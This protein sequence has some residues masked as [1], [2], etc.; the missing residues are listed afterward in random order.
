MSRLAKCDRSQLPE[1]VRLGDLF[2]AH[3]S[4]DNQRH[5]VLG[6]TFQEDHC[7]VRDRTTAHNPTLVREFATKFLKAPPANAP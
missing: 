5:H 2:R 7:Q 3:W 4:V 1:T 6:V